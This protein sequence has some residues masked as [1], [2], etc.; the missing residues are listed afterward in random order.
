MA[1]LMTIRSAVETKL[2]PKIAR[3]LRLF[4]RILSFGHDSI[5]V[6]TSYCLTVAIEA[7]NRSFTS[8]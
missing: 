1:G 7:E 3:F 6:A 8:D 5:V 4:L 2:L